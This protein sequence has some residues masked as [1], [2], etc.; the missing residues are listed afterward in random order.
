MAVKLARKKLKTSTFQA[1]I[2]RDP[3]ASNTMAVKD[4]EAT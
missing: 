4:K 2:P 3:P 1:A